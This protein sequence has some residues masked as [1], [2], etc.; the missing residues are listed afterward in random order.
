MKNMF[1]CIACLL[2][3]VG[4]S[5]SGENQGTL[6]NDDGGGNP[7]PPPPPPPELPL[8]LLTGKIFFTVSYNLNEALDELYCIEFPDLEP[9]KIPIQLD[10]RAYMD[11]SPVGGIILGHQ[12]NAF[13]DYITDT[14]FFDYTGKIL[15]RTDVSGE[16]YFWTNDGEFVYFGSYY[17]GIYEINTNT[18]SRIRL[19]QSKQNTYDHSVSVSPNSE[20]LAWSHR[21][22]GHNLT[23]YQVPFAHR[24]F[25]YNNAEII[26]T[27]S[28]RIFNEMQH[29]FFLDNTHYTISASDVAGEYTTHPHHPSWYTSSMYEID[30]VT[31]NVTTADQVDRLDSFFYSRDMSRIVYTH[32]VLDFSVVDAQS[33]ASVSVREDLSNCYSENVAWSID[34]RFICYECDNSKDNF[35]NN[36]WI[37]IYS[38]ADRYG[39]EICRFPGT[40]IGWIRWVE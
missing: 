10:W 37:I 29:P 16:E 38:F 28:T 31:K 1:F 32:W 34:D 7:P 3:V 12:Q 26:L 6:P 23:V 40:Y 25:T 8:D 20:T 2:L 9:K 18:W 35:V 30:S 27:T 24:P 5:D 22:W 11:V 15:Y 39:W 14:T 36:R 17:D 19:L 13:R 21:E 33:K 4:C